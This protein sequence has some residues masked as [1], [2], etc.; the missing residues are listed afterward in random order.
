MESIHQ[1]RCLI[2][3]VEWY[4]NISGDGLDVSEIRGKHIMAVSAIGNPASFEQTLS[5]LGAVII[6]SLRYPDHHDYTMKEMEEVLH[7]AEA[8]GVEAIVITEK[9]AV[10]IPAEV[11]QEE[12]GI[13]V[14]VICVEVTFQSGTDEFRSMLQE[15][16][17]ERLGNPMSARERMGVQ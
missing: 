1:P 9:D 12:W 13:P 2:P 7:Q 11:V 14:Y 6:E 15:K 5:D 8:Q 16:L 3:M 10:K 4:K 17:Q